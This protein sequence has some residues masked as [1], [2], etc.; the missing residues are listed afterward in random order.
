[1]RKSTCKYCI[2]MIESK[3]EQKQTI[4]NLKGK[5]FDGFSRT[6]KR[7]ERRRCREVLKMYNMDLDRQS[8]GR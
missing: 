7:K 5:K 3:K 6:G 2:C 1:M 8:R 4:T